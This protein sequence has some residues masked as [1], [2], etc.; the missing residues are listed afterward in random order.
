MCGL[1]F[2]IACVNSEGKRR[3]ETISQEAISGVDGFMKSSMMY[4]VRQTAPGQ[5]GRMS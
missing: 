3:E 2:D 4:V 1:E 5:R